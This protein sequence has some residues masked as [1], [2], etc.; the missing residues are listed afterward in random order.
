MY[1]TIFFFLLLSLC[2]EAQTT[3]LPTL[4]TEQV[5]DKMIAAHGGMSVWNATKT[6]Y[7]DHILAFGNGAEQEWWI[8]REMTDMKT[9]RT[10]QDW[11]FT[12][13]SLAFDGKKTWTTDWP[14]ENPPAMMVNNHLTAYSLPWLAKDARVKTEQVA[15][16]QLP[17]DS[18][19][20]YTLRLS[21]KSDNEK[22]YRIF[23]HPQSF[24]MAGWEYNVTYGAFLDLIGM[25]SEVKA[26]GPL[27]SV[28]YSYTKTDGIVFPSKYDTF[29][30]DGSLSG[31]HALFDFQRNKPFDES[32]M[33]MPKNAV[34]DTS[35]PKRKQ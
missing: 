9:M 34:V 20:Y 19:E 6:I 28:I 24:L 21:F 30:P 27:T 5:I 18:L 23:I 15:M 11:P 8:A 25:P 16:G 1:K 26:L 13:S 33:K 22:Y 12:K 29:G 14:N 7:F 31:I 32:R 3:S 4:S 2:S 17:G 35:S 10:Y